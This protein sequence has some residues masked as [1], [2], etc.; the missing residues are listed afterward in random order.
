MINIKCN[1]IEAE[2]DTGT[3]M[4]SVVWAIRNVAKNVECSHLTNKANIP[5]LESVLSVTRRERIGRFR[6]P[7]RVS[8]IT[9]ETFRV[10]ILRGVV[11]VVTSRANSEMHCW[12]KCMSSL[13]HLLVDRSRGVTEHVAPVEAPVKSQK[14]K[15]FLRVQ[16]REFSK[17]VQ[18][19]R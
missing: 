4:E 11:H 18:N 14:E 1:R 8:A 2:R 12:A 3:L 15:P 10:Y 13:T 9:W 19:W 6:K 7:Q 5:D 17:G 16:R